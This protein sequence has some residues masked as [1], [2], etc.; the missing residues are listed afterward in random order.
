MSNVPDVPKV[1]LKKPT[2]FILGAGASHPYGFPLGMELK[3]QMIARC[4]QPQARKILRSVGFDEDII[5]EMILALRGTYLPTIDIFLEKKT[6]FRSL[7][8]YLIAYTFLPREKHDA[9]FPQ[10]DW[11]AF[12]YK[13]LNFESDSPSGSGIS[14]VTLNYDRSL[15]HFLRKS[16]D[17]NCP[18][19]LIDSA[20]AK[21]RQIEIV[22][23][24]GSLGEYPA[25]SYG[26]GP[27]SEEVLRSAAERIKIVS[28]SLDGSRDFQ[29]SQRLV[30]EAN[31]VIFVGFGY[32]PRT[33]N[34]LFKDCT[35][36]EKNV[37]G[38]AFQLDEGQRRETGAFFSERIYLGEIS[39]TAREFLPSILL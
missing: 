14:F 38:T 32:D 7:G 29:R 10:H 20:Y 27:D 36:T 37:F 6:R 22:H 30:G 17:F 25:V 21:L 18:D 19:H 24:H 34:L 2:V 26:H 4:S 23:A 28:D 31:N 11:Y 39:A 8:A 15:E 5:R 35:P 1:E 12:L 33:L 16:I 13:F 3:A 9:L